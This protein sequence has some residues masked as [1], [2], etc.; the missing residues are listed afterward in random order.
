MK[1]IL[2]YV[3]IFLCAVAI[4]VTFYANQSPP[5]QSE[6]AAENIEALAQGET[7]RIKIEEWIGWG[8]YFFDGRLWACEGIEITCEEEG[9]IHCWAGIE[10]YN[11]F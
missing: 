8:V 1:R 4:S 10:I 9:P 2:T 11:C 7:A 6:L 5:E 3:I